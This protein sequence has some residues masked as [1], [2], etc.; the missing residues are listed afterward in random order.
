MPD[1]PTEETEDDHWRLGVQGQL[2]QHNETL[3]LKRK[4]KWLFLIQQDGKNFTSCQQ[5]GKL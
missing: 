4:Q 3:S 2:E 1:I 5:G